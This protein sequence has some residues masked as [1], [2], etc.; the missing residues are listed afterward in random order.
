MRRRGFGA[1]IFTA[2]AV[3]GVLLCG[4][5]PEDGAQDAVESATLVTVTE[6]RTR[7]VPVVLSSIGRLE[8]RASPTVAAEIDGRVLG[9]AVDEGEQVET[10]ALLATLDATSITLELKAAKAETGRIAAL[11]DNEERR[12]ERFRGL[13]QKGFIA[14][15]QLDDVEAQVAVLRAQQEATAA[16]L[17]IVEDQHAKTIIRSPLAGRIERRL[18]SPGDF[19]RRGTPLFEIATSER[20]RALLPFPEA[21]AQRLKPGLSVT[22]TSP[23]SPGY[24]AEGVVTEL[25][26]AVGESSRAVWAMVDIS[27]P[28][29]WRPDATVRAE[30]VAEVHAG[31][32]VVPARSLVRRPAGTLVYVIDGERAVQRVVDVGER[33]ADG[34]VEIVGGLEAG[35]T[36]ALEG[37]DYLSDGALVRVSGAPQ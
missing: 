9:L 25:R 31:A 30:I 17:R 33:L 10:G 4:C 26:P 19:V 18:V 21:L 2:A 28:G 7:D 3:L 20:L 37:A 1:R 14:R 8:S 22:L 27:N 36:V 11:L 29:A 6:A 24:S 13:H 32:V 12:L 5:S 15:E 23:L 16:R 35:E 34:S